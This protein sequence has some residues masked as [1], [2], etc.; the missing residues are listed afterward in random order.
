MLVHKNSVYRLALTPQQK[1]KKKD[2]LLQ[3]AVQT[4]RTPSF[5]EIAKER[6]D[7]LD[8]MAD[9]YSE[10][11][12]SEEADYDDVLDYL[13][14]N[15]TIRD[16]H[17]LNDEEA[18]AL[19]DQ[20]QEEV[21]KH[22]S[23]KAGMEYALQEMEEVYDESLWRIE[24]ELE[25]KDCW[26]VVTVKENVDP[27]QVDGLGIFWSFEKDAAEALWGGEHRRKPNDKTLRFRAKIDSRY[28]DKAGTLY[29]NTYLWGPEADKHE[30]RFFRNAPIYVY[31]VEVSRNKEDWE[32]V[33]ESG[34]W[35]TTPINDWRRC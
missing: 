9:E 3:Q 23:L 32:N 15:G 27:T 21:S 35:K 25:G 8:S 24:N 12:V 1:E 6:Q 22:L 34:Q 18:D 4:N 19:F 13:E 31:D 17:E 26:R 10:S 5:E 7:L 33:L 11:F 20:Y 30:V 2:Y 16:Q 14:A 28:I 29:A